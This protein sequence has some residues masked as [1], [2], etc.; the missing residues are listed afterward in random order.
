MELDFTSSLYLGFRHEAR[1]LKPWLQLTTGQPAVIGEPVGSEPIT[2]QLARLQGCDQAVLANS[3]LHLFWDLFGVLAT[4]RIAIFLDTGAYPIPRWGV[5]RA[6]ALGVPVYRFPHKNTDALDRLL[7]R[8]L[9]G[10]R[11]VVVSDGMCT[12]CGCAV[13]IKAY[14]ETVRH[15]GGLLVIDDTQ[16]LGILGAKPNPASPYGKGGGGSLQHHSISGP[17]VIIISSL[18]KGFGAPLAVLS[19][20]ADRVRTFKAKSQTRVHCSPP[21]A[22]AVHATAHALAL[23]NTHGD[24]LRAQLA[25]RVQYFRR[26]LLSSRISSDGGL[27]PVQTLCLPPHVNPE[28]VHAQLLQLGVRTILRR[29]CDSDKPSLALII[30]ARHSLNEIENAVQAIVKAVSEEPQLE[31]EGG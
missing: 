31:L 27:F 22:A 8:S 14:H 25:Q 5:E 13:P 1:S 26:H 2:Y 4:E 15:A 19:G 23:N 17:D 10:R 16:A 28:D 3:S 6:A 29:G 18:A 7:R 9:A 24:M 11:P 12:A 20:S 21:S 30:T